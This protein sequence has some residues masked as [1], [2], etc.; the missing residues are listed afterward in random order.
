MRAVN[1]LTALDCLTIMLSGHLHNLRPTWP[2]ERNTRPGLCGTSDNLSSRQG[3]GRSFVGYCSNRLTASLSLAPLD[4]PRYPVS[5]PGVYLFEGPPQPATDSAQVS[6]IRTLYIKLCVLATCIPLW[7]HG[8]APLP[9]RNP[10]RSIRNLLG[11]PTKQ[12]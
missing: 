6:K 7:I 9:C 10:T 11:F 5:K 4:G 1:K 12:G 8:S 2:V 3:C